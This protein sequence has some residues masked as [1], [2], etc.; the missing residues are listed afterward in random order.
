[1]RTPRGWG[2]AGRTAPRREAGPS[3]GSEDAR[4][5]RPPAPG[6]IGLLGCSFPGPFAAPWCAPRK[7]RTCCSR[8]PRG[9]VTRPM[10]PVLSLPQE[11][12]G[13]VSTE[14]GFG[15]QRLDGRGS[16]SRPHAPAPCPFPASASPRAARVADRT[17]P[18]AAQGC[19]VRAE[20]R[21]WPAA[22]WG[23]LSTARTGRCGREQWP[24]P[25]GESGA[26]PTGLVDPSWPSGTRLSPGGPAPRLWMG[27]GL[28]LLDLQAGCGQSSRP[29]SPRGR[30]CPG[31][32][33]PPPPA[34][35]LRGG[36]HAAASGR[37]REEGV[38]FGG[39]VVGRCR[40]D[41]VPGVWKQASEPRGTSACA[42]RLP[43]LCSSDGRDTD[44][45]ALAPRRAA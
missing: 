19:P 36:L 39:S 40:K 7:P 30:P 8:P 4:A 25:L 23:L 9:A 20:D 28:F 16:A 1:M 6:A 21:A 13:F 29:V 34:R 2:A 22:Q 12:P 38:G 14:D 45:S 42:S 43:V 10:L 44:S 32:R 15:R 5:S 26:A 35:G 27:R 18:G 3:Q 24:R 17:R 11:A 33:R 37:Q 31:G 41:L